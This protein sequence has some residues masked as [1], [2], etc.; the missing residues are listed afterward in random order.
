LRLQQA[1][2]DS[3]ERHRFTDTLVLAIGNTVG[4]GTLLLGPVAETLTLARGLE[5]QG[6]RVRRLDGPVGLFAV[7]A[8][9][10]GVSGP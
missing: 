9:A 7:T 2:G 1:L 6:F 10:S 5:A 8:P 4:N 3:G